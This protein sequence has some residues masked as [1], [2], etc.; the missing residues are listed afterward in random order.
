MSQ[1]PRTFSLFL[2]AFLASLAGSGS[3]TA[4]EKITFEQHVRPIFKTYCL[5]C[6]GAG[7]KLRGKLDLRLR[8][9]AVKGGTSG[10]AVVPQRRGQESARANV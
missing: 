5:D 7:E 8:R 2:A 3:A 6:H 1:P 10:P 4:A 9:F